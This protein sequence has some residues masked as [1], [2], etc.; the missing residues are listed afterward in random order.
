MANVLADGTSKQH[1]LPN[2]QA[3]LDKVLVSKG[4]SE[5]YTGPDRIIH[6]P[7]S[8]TPVASDG[9]A[10]TTYSITDYTLTDDTLT[11]SRRAT[12][13]EHIDNIEMLQTRYD[14]AK[15]RAERQAY[16]IADTIDQYMLALPV[17]MAGVTDITAGDFAGTPG[18]AYASSNSVV[19]DIANF[20]RT[21]MMLANS[22]GG[23]PFWVIS[24]YEAADIASFTQNNGFTSADAAIRNG[25]TGEN[26]GGLD[27]YVSNNLYH[28]TTLGL[29]TTPTDGDTIVINGV[30]FTFKTT[31]GSTAGNVLIGASA[32]AARA[33]LTALVNAPGTT[34]AQGVALSSANQA[35]LNRL[36]V[37]AVNDNALDTMTLAANG[38]LIVS[39]TLTNGTDTW[40][41]VVRHTIAGVKGAMFLALPSGGAEFDRKKVS[42]KHGEEF[43]TSQVYNGTI[44]TNRQPEVFDV[45][46]S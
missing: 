6:N 46:L 5:V 13:A 25:F 10:A 35:K 29:A 33:N 11:V 39:E 45:I 42:G 23:R 36:R 26:F 9:T 19:D 7:Y 21:S 17:S 20:I 31:L 1:W 24:P 18:A 12:S 8:S 41:T 22:G 38:T 27:I 3:N 40:A 4:I 16:T 43:V 44:W 32:D 34:T 2:F 30:T 15:D 37:V 28:T 14:L